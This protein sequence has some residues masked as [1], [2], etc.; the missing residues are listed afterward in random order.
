MTVR[1]LQREQPRS[2][3]VGV[4]GAQRSR[5]GGVGARGLEEEHQLAAAG[6]GVQHAAQQL[7]LK[8][9]EREGWSGGGRRLGK[10]SG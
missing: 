4:G 7:L 8:R 9:G 10:G 1:G 5:G 3:Q 6:E 2:E